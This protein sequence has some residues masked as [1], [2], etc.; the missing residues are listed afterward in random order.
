MKLSTFIRFTN[1]FCQPLVMFVIASVLFS[2]KLIVAQTPVYFEDAVAPILRKNCTACHNSK[3]SEGGLNLETPADLV[4]GGDSGPAFDLAKVDA[5][6]LITR[7]SDTAEEIMPP[8]DNKVG[9]ER[10]TPNQIATLKTWVAGGALS[11][12]PSQNM[13]NHANL[14]LPE[15]ARA[16]YAVAISPDSD[17]IA[18]GRG[19]QL[20]IHNAQRLA[21][22]QSIDGI[23][24][25]TPTQVIQDAH[26]DFIH[27]IA[28]SPDG[29]RIA[30]G[31]TGQVK[32]WR[33][34]E[35]SMDATRSTLASVG[36]DLSK[37]L[38]MSPDG[39][40]FATIESVP[41]APSPP[42]PSPPAPIPPAPIPT[43]PSSVPVIPAAKPTTQSC[44][45]KITKKDGTVLHSLA[46][47][48]SAVPFGVW[49]PSNDRFFALGSS[50][51]LYCWEFS[52]V[53]TVPPTTTPPTTTQLPNSIQSMVALDETTLMMVTTDRKAVVWQ[54]KTPANA[55]LVS[56]HPLATAINGAGPVDVV[57]IS[58]DR[59]MA[60]SVVQD[61]ATG[62]TSLKLWNVTQAKLA[63]AFER[64]RK[65]QLAMLNSDRELRRNQATLER[66]KALVVD[67][68]KAL[69]AEQAAVKAAQTGQ[70]KAAEVLAAK[71]KEMQAAVQ[72]IADH[73]KSMA[74]TK[75]AMD[76]AMLKLTQL[77]TE[78]EPKK[79]AL[80]ELEKQ[81][82]D[83]KSML[84]NAKQSLI[85]T[86]E[87]QKTAVIKL[88]ERKQSVEKQNEVLTAVQVKNASLKTTQ[89]AVRFSMQS[90]TFSGRDKIA[91][92]RVAEKTLTNVLD[93]FSVETLERVDSRPVA[94]PITSAAE[95]AAMVQDVRTPWEQESM[96]DSPSIVMDRA[97]AL[98][99]SP[100][101]ATLAIGS[102]LA[103]RNGQL[104]IVKVADG[105]M[106]ATMPDL[107]SDTIF[108]LAYSPDGRWLA[109]CGADKMT[110]LL[111][112]QTF[113]IA[114]LFEG[115]THHVLGLAWQE[116]ANRLA[117]ASSDTTVKIWD[118]EKGESIK[119]ITGFG[120]E[121]T[122][123]AF[124]GSTANT[125][126]STM[127]NLVRTHDSNTGKQNRQFGP[128]ADS[129][130]S[131]VA[132]PNG[133]YI[134]ATGQEGIARVWNVEDG[135]LVAEWK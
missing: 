123:L 73:E 110:K 76:A 45:V 11:R 124:I 15:N 121:V 1:R 129:L 80:T 4:R 128:T 135:K 100:D 75:L 111:N 130:Y 85:G 64:D 23:L 92:T 38:C 26:P 24:D 31:S 69:L 50:N 97:I 116:D 47:A 81:S 62:T 42:A 18:F 82:A 48:E 104:A 53:V 109:S 70:E 61:V 5:S 119:T 29:Q 32:V 127:N 12:G 125:V 17:F 102:G 37:L 22:A 133:K 108:G 98:A 118:I 28:I 132:S 20:V 83:S 40:L 134:A 66:S 39:S 84:E 6:L 113:E 120:T 88:E 13:A 105:S 71:E 115:H 16:S 78:L 34:A 79:K 41:P 74:E 77:T 9:A 91:A 14:R 60:C 106:I 33:R 94:Q 35:P 58:P 49:S 52:P 67:Y 51:L 27:S 43:D 86:E 10:L 19:G 7:P 25:V 44:N 55:E 59:L 54:F 112:A 57:R 65:D 30:T 93:F 101:G 63:G 72:G 117:T 8:V 21:G 99:F 90:V 126:S 3:L 87:N 89:E 68:E 36:I 46:I 103:S 95:L 56:D 107:H 96:L 114:K 122:S 2:S 131:V